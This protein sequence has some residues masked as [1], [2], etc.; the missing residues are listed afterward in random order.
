MSLD[1]DPDTGYSA[2][3]RK[4]WPRADRSKGAIEVRVAF[5][6]IPAVVRPDMAARVTFSG[7]R[8]EQP[9]EPQTAFIR[10]PRRAVVGSGSARYVFLIEGDVVRRLPVTVGASQG[11]SVVIDEGLEGGERLVLDPPKRLSDGD[12]IRAKG[13][14]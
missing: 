2:R 3:V 14:S 5:D 9:S 4:I 12:T 8:T 1:A 11:P 13:D 7:A 6:E 10:I